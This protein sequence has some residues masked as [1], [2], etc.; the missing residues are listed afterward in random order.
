MYSKQIRIIN[1]S[2]LHA[3][4]ASDLA[5]KAKE[6]ESAVYVKNLDV[7]GSEAVNAKSVIKILAEGMGQ[8]TNL[9]ISA[10]GPDERLAVDEL[11]ELVKSGFGEL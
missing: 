6:F 3:R 1:K 5:Q 7:E 10:E 2:G 9:E 11:Y 8:G 4:P